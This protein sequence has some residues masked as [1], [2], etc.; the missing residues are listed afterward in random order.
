MLEVEVI[1][2]EKLYLKQL[3][4][5][6]YFFV[7]RTFGIGLGRTQAMTVQNISCSG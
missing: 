2:K 1:K 5:I 6:M 3:L 7:L 4:N